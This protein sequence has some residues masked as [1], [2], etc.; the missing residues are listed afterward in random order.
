MPVIF[1]TSAVNC[2]SLIFKSCKTI[3]ALSGI[4]ASMSIS[5]CITFQLLLNFV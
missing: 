1:C 3:S 4:Y 5:C 2:I